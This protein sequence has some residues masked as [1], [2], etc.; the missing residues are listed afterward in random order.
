M[1]TRFVALGDSFTEGLH[2]EPRSDGRHRGWADRVAEQLPRRQGLESVQYANLAIRGRLTQQVVDEQLPAALALQPDM[3]SIA[4]GVNDVLRPA[5]DLDARASDLE[6]A[7]RALRAQGARVTVF[8][9]GDP[10]RRSVVLGSIA[11]RVRSLRSATLAIA[12]AYGCSLVDF[13]G[14]ARFDDERLWSPDRLHLSCQGH[15]V[16][17]QAVLAAWG[18][19]DHS[20]RSPGSDPQ[21][22]GWARRRGADVAWL[23]GHAGPWIW[24]RLRRQSSGDGV[25]P[26]DPALRTIHSTGEGLPQHV[27][28]L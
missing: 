25:E 11:G 22:P 15:A 10:T 28:Q 14:V 9:F 2:D 27:D 16:T 7:V 12:Q 23:R 19:G 17:A 26:K 24:R 20:W 8:A 1:I 18:L 13:W 6:Y 21:R 4:V 3:A 5:F